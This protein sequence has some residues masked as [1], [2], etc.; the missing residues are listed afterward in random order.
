VLQEDGGD[1]NNH[2]FTV[3]IAPNGRLVA[4]GYISELDIYGIS[5]V[6]LHSLYHFKYKET[7]RLP[8]KNANYE[9]N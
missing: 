5:A 7:K 3:P 4:I 6:F 9:G 8:Q 2:P 1:V